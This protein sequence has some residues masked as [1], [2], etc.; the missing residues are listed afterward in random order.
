MD[1]KR[2]KGEDSNGSGIGSKVP[3]LMVVV[4]GVVVVAVSR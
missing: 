3:S 4:S 2:E 1:N